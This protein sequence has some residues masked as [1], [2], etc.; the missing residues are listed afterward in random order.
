[1]PADLS[2]PPAVRTPVGRLNEQGEP[3]LYAATRK[4]TVFAELDLQAGEYVH[5]L[6]IKA[7]PEAPLRFIA[8]G[9]LI[10][11]IGPVT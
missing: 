1:M 3:C 8:I 9:E 7:K 5:L 6:G 11:F 4:E 2:Y 10:M